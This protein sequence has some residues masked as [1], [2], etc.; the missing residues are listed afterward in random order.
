MKEVLGMIDQAR[1][2]PH[3]VF[4]ILL[5]VLERIWER[6]ASY[7][8]H[9]VSGGHLAC[10]ASGHEGIDEYGQEGDAGSCMRKN[11]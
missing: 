2:P 10:M 3:D 8:L 9:L 1:V 11:Q 7:W 4:G 6:Q 5:D